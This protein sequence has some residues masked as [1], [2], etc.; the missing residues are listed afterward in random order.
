MLVVLVV[1]ERR[2]ASACLVMLSA[3]QGSHWYHLIWRGR[4]SN[5]RSPT[6]EADPLP[7]E[8]KSVAQDISKTEYTYKMLKLMLNRGPVKMNYNKLM[9]KW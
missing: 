6:L 7:L 5:L 2:E 9:F 8:L 3:K 1:S 4:V